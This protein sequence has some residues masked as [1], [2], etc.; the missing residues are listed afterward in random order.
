MYLIGGSDDSSRV[1]IYNLPLPPS[2]LCSLGHDWR[3]EILG[4]VD[5]ELAV[6]KDLYSRGLLV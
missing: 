3:L 6:I 5:D 4:E 2:T 1:F